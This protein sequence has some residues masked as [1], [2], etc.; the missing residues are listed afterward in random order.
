M[1]CPTCTGFGSTIS[2]STPGSDGN[3]TAENYGARILPMITEPGSSQDGTRILSRK[4]ER[5]SCWELWDP[6]TNRRRVDFERYPDTVDSSDIT[7]VQKQYVFF[8]SGTWG[9]GRRN[10]A[11]MLWSDET[12]IPTP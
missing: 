11:L 3:D 1:S 12:R 2:I 7:A 10:A 5:G 4:M 6:D 8:S 9:V